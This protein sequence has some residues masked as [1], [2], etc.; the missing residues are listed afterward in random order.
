[1][2]DEMELDPHAAAA[3]MIADGLNEDEDEAATHV[4]ASSQMG[5]EGIE[6]AAPN[7]ATFRLQRST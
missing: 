5:D 4:D 6:Y 3:D 1:M 7:P 2:E